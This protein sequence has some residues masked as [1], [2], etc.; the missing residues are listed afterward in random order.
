MVQERF[1][2]TIRIDIKSGEVAPAEE[3]SRKAAR[4]KKSTAEISDPMQGRLD[5][6]FS[7]IINSLYD[8]VLIV[9]YEGLVHVVN[10]RCCDIFHGESDQLCGGPVG[11]LIP[12]FTADV[13][14][15]VHTNLNAGIYTL[16]DGTCARVDD[17]TFPAEVAVS[18]LT[19]DGDSW[20]QFF[21]RDISARKNAQNALE[22]AYARLENHDRARSQFISNVSHEL[23]T[24]LT[25]MIYAIANI[26]KGIA[27]PLPDKLERYMLRLN[28]DTQR[29]LGTVNDILDLRRLED[30][31][32]VLYPATTSFSALVESSTE[33][34]R[35]HAESK[36][37]TLSVDTGG[38]LH[39]VECDMQ[40]IERVIQN[41]LNNAINYS[42]GRGSIEVVVS[43]SEDG[44]H[45]ICDVIDD[46]IG[47]SPEDL[48]RVMDRYFRVGE[49]IAG[50]GLGLAISKEIV[51]LHGG[52]LELS[53]PPP[54]REKGT[55]AR[56]TL[57]SVPA[58]TVLLIDD[59][60]EILNILRLQIGA[61]GYKTLSAEDGLMGLQ[62]MRDH[63]VDLVILDLV[64]PELEGTEV[65]MN[66]KGDDVL[67]SLPIVVLTGGHVDKSKFEIMKGFSIPTLSKPWSEDDLIE[68]VSDAFAGKAAFRA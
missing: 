54:G 67:R 18:S 36:G 33:S 43:L 46:G 13:L 68:I 12:G 32:L 41:L 39:F 11:D 58:P 65:I 7:T 35:L 34:L 2:K 29:L 4:S 1:T 57:A 28:S 49:Q 47:I 25:S 60:T 40:K 6:Q 42:G 62:L 17:T 45:A 15:Q 22:S 37:M 61:R 50:T 23:R 30:N 52:T 3:L 38:D 16:L 48:E 24:P 26:L 9:D 8:G 14:A 66:M 19:L 56:L 63:S 55:C 44:K 31:R 53:S 64:M 5:D 21:V 59:D 51:E 10:A 20:M 27:G